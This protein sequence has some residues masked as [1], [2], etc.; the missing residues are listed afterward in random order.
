MQVK[1]EHIQLHCGL[2]L[3][4]SNAANNQP[5]TFIT[6]EQ[7]CAQDKTGGIEVARIEFL[8]KVRVKKSQILRTRQRHTAS[9]SDRGVQLQLT[10]LDGHFLTMQN[11]ALDDEDFARVPTLVVPS[12]GDAVRVEVRFSMPVEWIESQYVVCVKYYQNNRDVDGKLKT[13][14]GAVSDEPANVYV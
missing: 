3:V 11:D 1:H 10:S 14:R 12:Q 7:K 13:A 2:R 4:K 6:V 5:R 8:A 9:L